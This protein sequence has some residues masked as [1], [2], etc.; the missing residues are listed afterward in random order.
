MASSNELYEQI[1]EAFEDDGSCIYPDECGIC[2][3]ENNSCLSENVNFIGKE[4]LQN[5]NKECRT[6]G[7]RVEKGTAIR[8]KS[9]KMNGNFESILYLFPATFFHL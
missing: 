1:E 6:W 9:L 2:N 3:G 5:A 8:G 7:I 4:A